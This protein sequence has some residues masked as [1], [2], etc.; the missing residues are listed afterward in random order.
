MNFS[1]LARGKLSL[2]FYFLFFYFIFYFLKCNASRQ[3][4]CKYFFMACLHKRRRF[5]VDF[6]R[7]ITAYFRR[8]GEVHIDSVSFVMPTLPKFTC[9]RGYC[10]KTVFIMF[11]TDCNHCTKL[12]YYYQ[13]SARSPPL[14]Y[15]RRVFPFK[16]MHILMTIIILSFDQIIQ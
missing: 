13:F 12:H 11:S 6:H 10:I 16:R 4:L 8:V 2:L 7:I 5:P 15:L 9:L 1:S 14:V 3:F